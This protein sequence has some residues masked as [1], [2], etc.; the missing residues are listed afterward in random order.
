MLLADCGFPASLRSLGIDVE[1]YQA[2]IP[3]MVEDA[4]QSRSIPLNPR[5]VAPGDLDG[6]YRAVL[7]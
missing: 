4:M 3:A 7:G 5:P 1:R 6:L 2:S